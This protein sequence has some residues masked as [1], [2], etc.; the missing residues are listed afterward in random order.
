MVKQLLGF[1]WRL[2]R[3]IAVAFIR[4]YQATLSPDHGPLRHLHPAGYCRHEPTCSMYG[5][6]ALKD[7]GFVVG[8]LL[9]MRRVLSCHP[10]RKPDDA[11]IRRLIADR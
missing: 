9:L 4:G 2:P 1:I 8:T 7:R 6:R 5:V 3:S 10:W 11:R